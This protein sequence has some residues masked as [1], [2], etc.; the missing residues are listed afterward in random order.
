MK[1]HTSRRPRVESFDCAFGQPLK[2][3]TNT[4]F[5]VSQWNGVEKLLFS[6]R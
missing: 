2:K 3:K 6:W 1:A 5:A 4:Q